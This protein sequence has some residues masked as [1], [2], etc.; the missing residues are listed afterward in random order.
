MNKLRK[1]P[2]IAAPDPN[3][4]NKSP[5]NTFPFRIEM[6]PM[7]TVMP[8]KEATISTRMNK[9]FMKPKLAYFKTASSILAQSAAP[10]VPDMS[11]NREEITASQKAITLFFLVLRSII[12]H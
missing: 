10:V 3:D 7:S 6:P 1:N 11:R 2:I 5:Q 8:P 12:S 4:I 9:L